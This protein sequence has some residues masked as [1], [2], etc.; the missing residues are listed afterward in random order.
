[1]NVIIVEMDCWCIRC[2]FI[3]VGVLSVIALSI[4]LYSG[5]YYYRYKLNRNDLVQTECTVVNHTV[6]MGL[7]AVGG[8]KGCCQTYELNFTV[9]YLVME[10]VPR[11]YNTSINFDYNK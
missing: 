7:F 11:L 1:M 8:R 2:I 3:I 9:N 10:D 4:P 5:G 6:T